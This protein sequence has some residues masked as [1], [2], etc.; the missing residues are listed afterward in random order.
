M[1]YTPNGHRVGVCCRYNKKTQT[2]SVEMWLAGTNIRLKQ[3][4]T[5]LQ[6]KLMRSCVYRYDRARLHMVELMLKDV[7][8]YMAR[9]AGEQDEHSTP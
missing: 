3:V 5:D 9:K 8:K 6:A 4:F 2:H 1:M 7:D